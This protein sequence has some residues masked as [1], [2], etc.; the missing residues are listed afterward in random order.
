MTLGLQQTAYTVTESDA[1]V[2]VCTAIQ[3]GSVG[4]RTITIDYETVD[5]DALGKF[6]VLIF[7]IRSA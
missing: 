3:S 7:F 2:I 6:P 5:G 4:G 1:I